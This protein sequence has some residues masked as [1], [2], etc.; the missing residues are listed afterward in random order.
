[1]NSTGTSSTQRLNQLA[2]A[3]VGRLLWSYSLP[4]VVGMLVI[5]LYNVIDRIFIGQGVGTEAIAGLAIT[6]PVSNVATALGV[7]IGVGA[8]AR[9][10]ILL[11]S[12][13]RDGASR[14]LGNSL[15]LTII[16]STVFTLVFGLMLKPVLM[17][18]GAS[19]VTLPYA[20]EFMLYILPGIA[21]S[22]ITYTFN[23]IMR[24]SGYPVRAMVT[25]L[26]GAGCNV[27]LAPI[28]IFALDMGIKGAAIATDLSMTVSAVFVMAHFFKPDST[29]RFTRGIYALRWRV[30]LAI[31]SIG[32]S[33]SLV[34]FASSA[35]NVVINRSL[36]HHGGDMAVGAAGIFTTF[37][38]LLVMVV[39]GICQGM[40]PVV[41]YNYGAGLYGRLKRAF[42]L[43]VVWSSV[44]VS[45]G[46]AVGLAWPEFVARAF[47][48]DEG[49]ISVTATAFRTAM[50]VFFM[51]GFQVVS[52]NL[53]MS[54]GKARISILLSL[55]RQVIFLI[56]LLMILPGH[57]GLR[58]VW[59]SF[60]ISDALATLV[61]FWTVCLLWRN[62]HD[63]QNA[64]PAQE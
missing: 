15:I 43:A 20:Y 23:S 25:M 14:V 1:M 62:L 12:N 8:S 41:G 40:Q 48:S 58:G 32:A 45:L 13:D 34:N 21:M 54:L 46:W 29:V 27:V 31:I 35:I 19:E 37:T 33:P 39:I 63:M 26:I 7:L 11:G 50:P 38:S 42:T 52:T 51:V 10:S 17:A 60:P 30:V 4:S 3:P 49:L 18:F 61:T 53:F 24:A 47:T 9:V 44:V 57:M 36:V 16:N 6:F 2:T 55:A 22:N 5:S 56:P 59:L 64:R 28:F